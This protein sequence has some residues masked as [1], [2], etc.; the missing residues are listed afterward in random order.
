MLAVVPLLWAALGG[1]AHAATGSA[2]HD[3]G[4]DLGTVVLLV[5]VIGVAYVLAHNVVERLQRRFLVVTGVE[6]LLLGFL[7]G[8]AFPAIH[9]LDDVTGLLPIIALAAGWVGLL[10]GT[11][12]D[13]TSLQKLDPATWRVVFL[14]HLLP[15]VTVGFGSYYF[16]TETGWVIV[17]PRDAMLSSAALACF[18]AT[19]SSEPFDLL[20]RRYE[21]SGRLAPLLRNGTRLG[22]IGV[23]LAFGLIFCVFHENAPEAQDYSPSLWAWVT[24]LL[25]AALGFLFSLFLV[26]DESDNS[27][28]LAL[29]GIIAFASGGAYFLELS[30]L[31]VNLSMGF[32]LVNFARGGQ[33]LHTTLESTERPMALVLLVF[34]G[35]LWERTELVPTLLGLGGFLVVRTSAKWLASAIAGWGTSLRKDLFRGLLAHGDVTL[36]MAVSFRLVYDG[37]AAKIAY[38]VVLGSVIL[39]GL[40]APRLLRGLLVDE[41]EIQRE[42]K[43]SDSRTSFEV[44]T[45]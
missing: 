1:V 43:D 28:F 18:A 7:L 37:E 41:G 3:S 9:A 23:I 33:L 39:N 22:D 20:A 14:H 38:S 24:V 19:D 44:T 26:G 30:P 35:A 40:M 11:D 5:V 32:V 36:A 13:F 12:F 29:V 45:R 21:I 15:A 2:P 10:R 6:Y 25:G 31:A 16:F 8:P 17:S 4:D 42:L 27:R 34:A